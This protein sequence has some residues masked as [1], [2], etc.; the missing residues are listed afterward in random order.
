MQQITSVFGIIVTVLIS[1]ALGFLVGN[2]LRYWT[3]IRDQALLK[4]RIDMHDREISSMKLS[5]TQFLE[6]IKRMRHD[7]SESLRRI[8]I[9]LSEKEDRE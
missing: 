6:E 5:E 2:A 3:V 1:S 7:F 9:A 4:M 8:E